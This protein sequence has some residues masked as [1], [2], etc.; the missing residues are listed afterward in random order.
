M[1]NVQIVL[2]I[3]YTC[4]LLNHFFACVSV[5]ESLG[6]LLSEDDSV[7]TDL[8][9]FIPAMCGSI[10][11]SV[12]WLQLKY[13]FA[14]LPISL[15]LPIRDNHTALF[16]THFLYDCIYTY[17]VLSSQACCFLCRFF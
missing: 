13:L 9:L 10:S 3:Y 7:V 6:R 2:F 11:F 5:S 15:D 8:F 17:L 14:L 4:T 1:N 16:Y 12:N